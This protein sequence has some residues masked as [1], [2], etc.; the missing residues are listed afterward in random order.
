MLGC[1]D[2][3][4]LAVNSN[5]IE[6]YITPPKT[7][8]PA[9]E[10]E[11]NTLYDLG[12]VP[13]VNIYCNFRTMDVTTERVTANGNESKSASNASLGWYLKVSE[14]TGAQ[15]STAPDR[16]DEQRRGTSFFP[17][18]VA[19]LPTTSARGGY[20]DDASNVRGTKTSNDSADPKISS[21]GRK[22]KWLKT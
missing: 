3:D 8:L 9:E 21:E 22:P 11:G 15:L 7:I 6:L 20:T 2:R 1:L 4:N 14:V 10:R 16:S 19:L 17:T 12:M 5:D 18:G 13:A